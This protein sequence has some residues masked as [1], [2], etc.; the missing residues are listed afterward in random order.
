MVDTHHLHG[1]CRWVHPGHG[2]AL[3][4][5]DQAPGFV[6]AVESAH[7]WELPPVGVQGPR[8]DGEVVWVEGFRAPNEHFLSK[9]INPDDD[10]DQFLK[11]MFRLAPVKISEGC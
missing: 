3:L 6:E 10:L 9:Q 8:L 2:S 11:L 4:S 7:L 5:D 1:Q